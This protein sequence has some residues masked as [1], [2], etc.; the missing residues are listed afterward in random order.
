MQRTKY[1]MRAVNFFQF[2]LGR[3]GGSRVASRNCVVRAETPARAATK[4]PARSP[5]F[6]SI[7]NR[8]AAYLSFGAS[9]FGVS[10]LGA[11]ASAF[12]ASGAL[13]ASAF[14]AS[15]VVGGASLAELSRI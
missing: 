15:G 3:G 7:W 11:G 13:G 12:G 1:K 5:V 8:F 14:G 6:R 4:K 2:G 10:A 9:S